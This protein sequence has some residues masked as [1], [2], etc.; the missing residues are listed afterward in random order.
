MPK[1]IPA[2]VRKIASATNE[3]L[4]CC[5]SSA[6]RNQIHVYKYYFS[7]DE[8]KL[9]S[10]WSRWTFEDDDHILDIEFLASDLYVLIKR[11]DGLYLNRI[12]VEMGAVDPGYPVQIH[13]DRKFRSED[14]YKIYYP[15]GAGLHEG[16]TH[17][18]LP[19][20]VQAD[21]LPAHAPTPFIGVVLS[22]Q[23]KAE[24]LVVPLYGLGKRD[25]LYAI[26]DYEDVAMVIGRQYDM[27]YELSTIN[28]KED[29]VGGGQATINEGRLQL[30][31]MTLNIAD[32]GYFEVHV[33]PVGRDPY[34]YTFTG[35][36]LGS[37]NNILNRNAVE[38]GTFQFPILARNLDVT[39][40]V[41]S[42]SHRPVA[43]MNAEWEGF[44]HARSRRL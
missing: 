4:L 32:T 10:S 40:A 39:I 7:A 44:Y 6:A 20:E 21:P 14:V 3:D 9:Q 23:T 34:V 36:V 1:Y 17:F 15:E 24:G 42:A 8:E 38:T 28:L 19:Y 33:T 22:G 25:T 37:A 35:R 27:L 5:L 30:R 43:I 2:T 11:H 26:G 13:L 29:A 31:K 12:G 16:Q 41:K 18:A